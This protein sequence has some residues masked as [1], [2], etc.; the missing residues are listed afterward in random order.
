MVR[1]EDKSKIVSTCPHSPRAPL[2]PILQ[3]EVPGQVDEP[4]PQADQLCV[5]AWCLCSALGMPSHN[6]LPLI[7]PW[8]PETQAPLGTRARRSRGIPSVDCTERRILARL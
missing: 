6:Y 4:F 5:L 3:A 1:S 8:G 2:K 7:V